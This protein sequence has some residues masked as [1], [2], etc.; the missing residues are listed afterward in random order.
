MFHDFKFSYV[1]IFIIFFIGVVKLKVYFY[2]SNHSSLALPSGI[3]K[4]YKYIFC[5]CNMPNL[6]PWVNQNNNDYK[7]TA[8]KIIC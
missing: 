3:Y 5:V 7:D 2:K 8:T 1:N 4:I 6:D